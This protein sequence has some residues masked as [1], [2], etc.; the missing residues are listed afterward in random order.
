M[1]LW[2][3]ICLL[4]SQLETKNNTAVYIDNRTL[5]LEED[6]EGREEGSDWSESLPVDEAAEAD[7]TESD[8]MNG[9]EEEEEEEELE[10]ELS[11]QGW[12]D[13]SSSGVL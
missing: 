3:N 13:K 9:T 1:Y 7:S 5:T 4:L 2:S 12:F 8:F 10:E 11:N 6:E